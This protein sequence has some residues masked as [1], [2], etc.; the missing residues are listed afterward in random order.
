MAGDDSL[1]MLKRTCRNADS[2]LWQWQ[3]SH[4]VN[5]EGKAVAVDKAKE[6]RELVNNHCTNSYNNRS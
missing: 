2:L 6:G 5:Q 3:G 4:L 1:V